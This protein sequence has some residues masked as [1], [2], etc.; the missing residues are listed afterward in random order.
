M[1]GEG[2]WI[3]DICLA[4]EGESRKTRS[5]T[6]NR[7]SYTKHD[8]GSYAV[9]IENVT[10]DIRL[11]VDTVNYYT[12]SIG[13]T[14]HG[15]ITA[16]DN[17]GN[18][19]TDGTAVAEGSAVTFTATP[20]NHYRFAKWGGDAANTKAKAAN[21]G[22][23]VSVTLTDI[24][25]DIAVSAEFAM[26]DHKNTEVRGAKKATC[27]EDG[28]TGDTYCTDCGALVAKGQVIKATGHDYTQTAS[29]APTTQKE[30]TKTYTCRRCGHSYTESTE[31]LPKPIVVK[32]IR[33]GRNKNRLS[34]NK[35]DGADGYIILAD[36]CNTRS[37][38]QE[39]TVKRVK[40]VVS[41][42][43]TTWIHKKLKSAAWYKYQIKAFKMV[44]GKR[45]VISET[46]VVHAVTA[47]STRYANPVKVKVNKT[48]ISVKAGKKKKIKASVVLPKN[49]ICQQH[50]D[51]IRYVVVDETIAAVNRKGV[52]KAKSKGTTTVYAIAQN[53]VS[54]KITVTVK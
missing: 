2:K 34:W 22:E 37:K 52:I 18:V 36:T 29:T 11:Q 42:D 48:K 45:V 7:L 32:P 38:K 47:G 27:T 35:V 6:G 50:C 44:N 51:E 23:A 4:G 43:R 12:V 19:I 1:P 3:T 40:T 25:K 15:G 14:E 39:K 24:R 20:D 28:Y 9:T 21:R 17:D 13:Q 31:M 30:G 26:T 33:A 5:E 10:K 54:K 8:D 49:R 53:G 41:G 46:P 16:R